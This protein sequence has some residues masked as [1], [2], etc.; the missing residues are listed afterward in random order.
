MSIM[1]E[2]IH[3]MAAGGAT[4]AHAVAAYP[5]SLFGGGTLDEKERKKRKKSA[6]KTRNLSEAAAQAYYLLGAG[7]DSVIRSE[8]RVK[9]HVYG[10]VAQLVETYH[11]DQAFIEDWIYYLSE[12]NQ[13]ALL[14]DIVQLV[15]G[16]QVRTK[17][18]QN[19]EQ[20]IVDSVITEMG[21]PEKGAIGSVGDDETNFD[22]SDVIAKLDAAEKKSKSG[23]D[24]QAFGL[25]DE[26]GNIIKVYVKSEHGEEFE[27]ALAA[28]LAGTD[29]D[30]NEEVSAPEIAEVL[31]NL[32]DK[33]DIVDVD[34]GTI[35][36][37]EEQEQTAGGGE[38]AAGGA[39]GGGENM[40]PEGEGGEMPPGGEGEGGANLDMEGGEEGM[41]G[42]EEGMEGGEE[43]MEDD[44]EAD[45]GAE[46]ALQQVIDLLKSNADAQKAEAEARTA[47]AKAKEA[48][49]SAKSAGH[50]VKQEEQLLD[51]E[52]H[53]DKKKKEKEETE[54]IGKL[55]KF[56]HET[57]DDAESKLSYGGSEEEETSMTA[58]ALADELFKHLRKY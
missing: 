5:G 52:A 50:K 57:A 44:M 26:E 41:E 9:G 22:A 47:E 28:S 11:G 16:A 21:A 32:K 43:G 24:T 20:R 10:R 1:K 36:G 7:L 17:L 18:Y 25:E 8:P 30:E 49:Y 42:G 35:S 37:D 40:P 54:R 39:Q 33:F 23:E 51:V 55:A 13:T 3:E 27:A 48:E 4:S 56:K 53:E 2:M 34:W 29:D 46:S 31:F 38:A 58:S 45:T 12:D 15:E 14:K 6:K 19:T